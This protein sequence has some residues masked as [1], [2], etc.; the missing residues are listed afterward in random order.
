MIRMNFRNT[1]HVIAAALGMGKPI[2]STPIP[3]GVAS[4]L[5]SALLSKRL[6]RDTSI[7]LPRR[8]RLTPHGRMRLF[9]SYP[10]GVR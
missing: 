3:M 10:I 9:R 5:G 2:P 1:L 6:R 4:S 7:P 8:Q